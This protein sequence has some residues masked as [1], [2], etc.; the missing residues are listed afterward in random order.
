MFLEE[1]LS[2]LQV[3][4]MGYLMLFSLLLCLCIQFLLLV[5]HGQGTRIAGGYIGSPMSCVLINLLVFTQMN[6]AVNGFLAWVVNHHTSTWKLRNQN[7][8]CTHAYWLLAITC[9]DENA[10]RLHAWHMGNTCTT[11]W[12]RKTRN[13]WLC[14]DT[15]LIVHVWVRCTWHDMAWHVRSITIFI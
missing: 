2:L 14:T 10:A 12:W 9:P 4:F 8:K 13:L 6:T 3:S 7:P 11:R 15:C 1:N 5:P